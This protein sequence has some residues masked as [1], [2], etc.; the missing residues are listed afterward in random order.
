MSRTF[1]LILIEYCCVS[2]GPNYWLTRQIAVWNYQTVSTCCLVLHALRVCTRSFGILY[3]W[4]T[5]NFSFTDIFSLSSGTVTQAVTTLYSSL[6]VS[7]ILLLSML[8]H[9][10]HSLY[11]TFPSFL[12]Q[13]APFLYV[14]CQE[15]IKYSCSCVLLAII[16]CNLCSTDVLGCANKV[17]LLVSTKHF[18][19]LLS[20]Y[21]FFEKACY[22]WQAH[23]KHNTSVVLCVYRKV[24]IVCLH[25]LNS[26]YIH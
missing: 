5:I 26:S 24:A 10:F 25:A 8:S 15:F 6:I 12:R 22:I 23:N 11:V 13:T 9:F 20:T 14:S 1:H 18:H 17:Y 2:L 7:L 16:L 3:F 21:S 4:I 19:R